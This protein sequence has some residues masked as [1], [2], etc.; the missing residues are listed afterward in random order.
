LA[1]IVRITTRGADGARA[2]TA[3][4]ADRLAARLTGVREVA[5]IAAFHPVTASDGNGNGNA[6]RNFASQRSATVPA[7]GR[8]PFAAYRQK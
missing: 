8:S 1:S 7:S 2:R 3:L 5:A 6:G 4:I